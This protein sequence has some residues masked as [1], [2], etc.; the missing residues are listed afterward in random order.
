MKQSNLLKIWSLT[1]PISLC[2]GLFSGITFAQA[3][4]P[5]FSGGEL[6]QFPAKLQ[7]YARDKASNTAA[8][9]VSGRIA[10]AQSYTSVRLKVFRDS[11]R[12]GVFANSEIVDTR[13]AS[14]SAPSG[15]YKNFS[16]TPYQ[17]PAELYNY[18]FRFI[19]VSS[20][21]V[22]TQL[23]TT[24]SVVA[25][26]VYIIQGQSNAEAFNNCESGLYDCNP[27]SDGESFIRGGNPNVSLIRSF[28]RVYGNGCGAGWYASDPID[29]Y[30]NMPKSWAIGSGLVGR[31]H[32]GF[33]HTGQWGMY[34]SRLIAQNHGIPV[35]I[36][37]GAY[38]AEIRHFQKNSTRLDPSGRNNYTS[39]LSRIQEAGLTNKI[40]AI[41]WFQGESN[42]TTSEGQQLDK[43]GYKA[44][45]NILYNNWN[46]DYPSFSKL[47]VFQVKRGCF[48]G[49]TTYN[50]SLTP[51]LALNIMQAQREIVAERPEAV[52]ISSSNTTQAQDFG[53][54]YCH[55]VYTNGYQ[56]V[57]QRAYNQVKRHI[58]NT[59]LTET[60]LDSPEPD[61]A[62]YSFQVP[63]RVQISLKNT[64][65]TYSL[66]GTGIQNDFR[67]E[68]DGS[69]TITSVQLVDKIIN[70]DYTMNAG[71]VTPPTFVSYFGHAGL[72]TPSISNAT[73]TGLITFRS[74]PIVFGSLPVDP[75]SLT[76]SRNGANNMLRWKIETNEESELFVVERGENSSTFKDL[77]E[78][79]SNGKNG[80]ES[81]S[82]TDSKPNT[83]MSHYRIRA[84]KNN[85]KEIFSQVV[86]INN[87]LSEISDFRVYPNPVVHAANATVTLK[88]SAMATIQILDASG[89]I[90]SNRKLQ[91]QKGNNQFAMDELVDLRAGTYIVR[92]IS[93]TEVQQVRVVKSH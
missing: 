9:P 20:G 10:E 91:L 43:D 29:N 56:T 69:Y 51:N 86:T 71:T 19:G 63:N 53:G 14:L 18:Q 90:F 79:Y 44:E 75:L 72:A 33:R 57:G 78:I 25:G 7:F 77:K 16:F 46:L 39:L 87:R 73:G 12:N 32:L 76:V 21:N 13:N 26:D 24:D 84:I 3:P 48:E 74:L 36:F 67:L 59:G 8:V 28:V 93:P 22:E 82:F 62:D 55:Y 58:Y 41:F 65:D 23:A 47:Y 30:N 70:I 66:N 49:S 15:G 27:N 80:T 2:L 42:M 17:L 64:N 11:D 92:I 85:G 34:F 81:Y 45:F 38:G 40:T 50:P 5:T 52:L 61:K 35:C 60:N 89:R 4:I 6:F 31:T 54:G 68:G 37:N 88:S 1:L 83:Q